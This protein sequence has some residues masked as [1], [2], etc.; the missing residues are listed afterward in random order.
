MAVGDIRERGVEGV[1]Q[2]ATM[3]AALVRG[4]QILHQSR[5]LQPLL[6]GQLST[7]PREMLRATLG[8]ALGLSL[9]V[10][11]CQQVFGTAVATLLICLST[12][13]LATIELLRR[14]NERM[15]GMSAR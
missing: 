12:M 6:G 5:D 15:R 4:G 2:L 10:W 8:A 14:R 9:S 11:L 1:T 3:A 7:H 13:L